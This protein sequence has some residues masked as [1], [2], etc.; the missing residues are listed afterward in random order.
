MYINIKMRW[1]RVENCNSGAEILYLFHPE[2]EGALP[3]VFLLQM[4]I[5]VEEDEVNVAFQALQAPQQQLLTILLCLT[6]F[7]L[8]KQ[9]NKALL[10]Y[11]VGKTNFLYSKNCWQQHTCYIFTFGLCTISTPGQA[12]GQSLL[13]CSQFSVSNCLLHV[14]RVCIM[15]VFLDI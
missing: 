4:Q 15:L 12:Y 10:V 11:Q 1:S 6:T 7:D 9:V 3:G 5:C 13:Y 2:S 14:G 8:R